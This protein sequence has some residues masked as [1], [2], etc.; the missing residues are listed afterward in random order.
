LF[1]DKNIFGKYITGYTA[2]KKLN[3]V[4]FIVRPMRT[5]KFTLRVRYLHFRI[6]INHT[7]NVQNT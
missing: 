3:M 4:I 6:K 7:F 1:Q 5:Q 2:S